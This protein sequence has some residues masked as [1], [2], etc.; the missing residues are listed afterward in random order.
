MLRR[1]EFLELR[2][3]RWELRSASTAETDALVREATRLFEDQLRLQH[4]CL[5]DLKPH[6][7]GPLF[8]KL[9]ELQGAV[10]RN[11]KS[12]QWDEGFRCLESSWKEIGQLEQALLVVQRHSAL[13]DELKEKS[14]GLSDPW[15]SFPSI[16]QPREMLQKA[17]SLL[18]NA[19]PQKA[20]G[21]LDLAAAWI[22]SWSKTPPEPGRLI[23][24]IGASSLPKPGG[25]LKLIEAGRA[26]L[27]ASLLQEWTLQTKAD[28]G[29][30]VQ[31]LSYQPRR[32]E[33][34][35]LEAQ[36]RLTRWA[37]SRENV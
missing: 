2:A 32:L 27:V 9:E 21:A 13:C 33:R 8:S 11:L 24:R 29:S 35:A 25:L 3:K 20:T 23:R 5:V 28:A 31:T 22:S 6:M 16:R 17:G 1:S 10:N 19:Q 7:P 18:L 15:T 26:G 14:R 36:A 37:Q 4:R 12:R 30:S 34:R